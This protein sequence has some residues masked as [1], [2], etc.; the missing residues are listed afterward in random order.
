MRTRSSTAPHVLYTKEGVHSTRSIREHEMARPPSLRGRVVIVGAGF[1]G[2]AAARRLTQD[3]ELSVTLLEGSA[4]VGGRARSVEPSPGKPVAD[5]GCTWAYCTADPGNPAD[6]FV[7]RYAGEN[8]H[9]LSSSLGSYPDPHERNQ[10]VEAHKPTLYVL[11]T[12]DKL[13]ST[14]VLE[15]SRIYYKAQKELNYCVAA[16]GDRSNV[17]LGSKWEKLAPVVP[18]QLAG[19]DYHDYITKRCTDAVEHFDPLKNVGSTTTALEP[20]HVLRHLLVFAGSV[21][22]TEECRGVDCVS[23]GDFEDMACSVPTSG[24]FQAIAEGIASQLPSGCLHLD[25]EVTSIR[26]TSEQRE[27]LHHPVLVDCSDGVTY[28]TDHVILTLSLGVLKHK[29]DSGTSNPLFSPPLPEQKLAAIRKLGMG[30]VNKLLLEFPHPL[31]GDKAGSIQLYWRDEELDFP[32][33]YPWVRKLDSLL[34]FHHMHNIYEVWLT[35]NNA[36]AIESLPDE[37]I[38]EGIALVLEKFLKEPV[39][40]PNVIHSNWCGDRLFRGSYSYNRVGNSRHDREDLARPVDGSTGLQLLFAGEATHQTLYSSVNGAFSS[41]ERE[42]EKLL[43]HYKT[44][45]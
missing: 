39:K 2:L 25:K 37:E 31:A 8:G 17:F 19:V 3:S 36:I 32:E 44:R 22:G 27:D 16:P 14:E 10:E 43:E 15:C 20:A 5:L 38:A 29:C 33:K 24:G 30:L 12:G 21:E 13:H 28:E 18:S 11:S 6:N 9:L 1:A 26:W 40:R 4:R 35:G 7:F 41:G 23:Y 42:A 34:R 45:Q